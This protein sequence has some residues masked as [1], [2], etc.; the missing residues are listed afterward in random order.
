M[1]VTDLEL[2]NSLSRRHTGLSTTVHAFYLALSHFRSSHII[3]IVPFELGDLL[4]RFFSRFILVYIV[5]NFGCLLN[6]R[7]HLQGTPDEDHYNLW[8]CLWRIPLTYSL[9]WT[10]P[11]P[12]FKV[13]DM[14]RNKQAEYTFIL[15]A[16]SPRMQYD[17][18]LKHWHNFSI[19][20]FY[21]ASL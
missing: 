15:P 14:K 5:I 1:P 6:R 21:F 7:A 17:R 9:M 10:N 12:G 19:F 13:F 20:C 18:F 8:K 11:F 4:N 3:C 16:S 2:V